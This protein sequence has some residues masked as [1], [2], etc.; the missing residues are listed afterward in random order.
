LSVNKNKKAFFNV[1]QKTIVLADTDVF[2][3]FK[4]LGFWDFLFFFNPLVEGFI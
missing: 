2:G 4:K 3:C 1:C